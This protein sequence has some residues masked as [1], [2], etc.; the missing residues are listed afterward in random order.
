M[1]KCC[2]CNKSTGQGYNGLHYCDEHHPQSAKCECGR[3]WLTW[4][5]SQTVCPLCEFKPGIEKSEVK[6]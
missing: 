1:T 5:T 6:E 2:E 3:R 4:D